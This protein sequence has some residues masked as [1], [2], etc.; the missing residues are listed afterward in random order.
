MCVFTQAA[1]KDS[2]LIVF[3]LSH[4]WDDKEEDEVML[5]LEMFVYKAAAH[6]G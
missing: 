3:H 2:I 4:G 1:A 5:D 6:S